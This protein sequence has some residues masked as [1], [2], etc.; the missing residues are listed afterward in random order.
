MLSVNVSIIAVITVKNV[1][2]RSIVHFISKSEAIN[3]SKSYVLE[4]PGYISKTLFWHFK[5]RL[6]KCVMIFKKAVDT[7]PPT[8]KFVLECCMTQEM[9]DEEANKCFFVFN[10]ILSI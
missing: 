3:L 1:N 7:D 9:C 10:S 5:I 2:Y 4:D 8:I 6:K